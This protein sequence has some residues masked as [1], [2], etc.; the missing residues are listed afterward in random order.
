MNTTLFQ[1]VEIKIQGFG[2]GCFQKIYTSLSKQCQFNAL[3]SVH[4][5]A[6]VLGQF[7]R[8]RNKRHTDNLG[9]FIATA[10]VI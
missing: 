1:V 10:R 4:S 8:N 2:E 5:I 7:V 3:R 9:V 6:F